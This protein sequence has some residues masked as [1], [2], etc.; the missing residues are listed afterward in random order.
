MILSSRLCLRTDLF[1]YNFLFNK[2]KNEMRFWQKTENSLTNNS[3]CNCF[4]HVV[5]WTNDT[6]IYEYKNITDT[7]ASKF[8]YSYRRDMDGHVRTFP[9]TTFLISFSGNVSIRFSLI[10]FHLSLLAHTYGK[11]S[12]PFRKKTTEN[13]LPMVEWWIIQKLKYFINFLFEAHF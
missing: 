3:I 6:Q 7:P 13:K 4:H 11:M 1:L 5:M 10:Q 9:K 12:F 8:F 2:K